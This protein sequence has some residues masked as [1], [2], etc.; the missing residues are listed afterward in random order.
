MDDYIKV[1]K[2]N[3]DGMSPRVKIIGQVAAGLFLGL[4]LYCSP[5]VVIRENYAT[6][7]KENVFPTIIAI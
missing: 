2:K 7:N 1:F 3:K 6:V 4:V 5:D